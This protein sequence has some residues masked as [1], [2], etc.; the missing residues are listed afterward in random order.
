MKYKTLQAAHT[1]T[2]KDLETRLHFL[3]LFDNPFN[4]LELTYVQDALANKGTLIMTAYTLDD[5]HKAYANW[6]AANAFAQRMSRMH[7]KD[8]PGVLEAW[9]R[10]ERAL[11]RYTQINLAFSGR[12]ENP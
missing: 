2:V 4:K 7:A 11:E 5:L 9:Q 3:K 1:A 12:E 8:N 10:E 6:L